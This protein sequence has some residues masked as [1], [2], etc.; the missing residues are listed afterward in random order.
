MKKKEL[1]LYKHTLQ[2][3]LK[4]SHDKFILI[5]ILIL[6]RFFK[7]G[8][9]FNTF[10]FHI[11]GFFWFCWQFN[12]FI[13]GFCWPQDGIIFWVLSSIVESS[14]KQQAK[15]FTTKLSTT[16]KSLQ[17]GEKQIFL[18]FQLNMKYYTLNIAHSQ[19][20]AEP[21]SSSHDGRQADESARRHERVKY[22]LDC[23]SYFEFWKS[24]W[25]LL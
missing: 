11:F 4:H 6:L 14:Q 25:F 7:C 8:I 15:K 13:P 23:V 24:P 19:A 10:V 16:R 17:A 18:I 5:F 1:Q 9:I 20:D 3:W 12:S 21:M 2:L 22:L